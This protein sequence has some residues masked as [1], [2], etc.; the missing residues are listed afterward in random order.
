[1]VA[2]PA[3]AQLAPQVAAGNA[4]NWDV[5]QKLYP[6]RALA[7]HEEGAV[8]FDVTLDS[9]GAVTEC[10]VTHSSGHPLLDEETCRIITLNA[11]FKPDPAASRSQVKKFPGLIAWKL[12]NSTAA[13]ASP[14]AVK[15]ASAPEKMIC[16]KIL[17]TGSNAAFER[18]CM[19][20][21]DWTRQR[22][23]TQE[24]W[25]ELQG[26]KGSTSGN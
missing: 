21:L 24:T 10:K 12:P 8:G 9:Q 17:R 2:A 4:S 16:H 18:T 6:S 22:S 3:T 25:G 20:Q 15:T 23:D 1:M 5:F 7:V 19:T 11:Q 14:V 13:L 26:K